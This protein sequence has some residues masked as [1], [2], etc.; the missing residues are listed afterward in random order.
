MLKWFVVLTFLLTS[1]GYH[2]VG[3]GDGSVFPQMVNTA[4]L[5]S[6]ASLTG[7]SIAA[8]LSFIWQQQALLPALE[9]GNSLNKEHVVV[10]IEQENIVFMPVG[11][12][13]SGLAVQYRLQ[14]SAMLRMYHQNA[15]IWQSGAIMVYADVFGASDPSVTEAERERL[16]EQLYKMW[17]KEALARLKSGF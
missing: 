4:T 16:T 3:Q 12:D 17:A 8:E 15:L 6:N 5:Q 7:K 2:L 10:R 11:F 9:A 13:A 1:C 14:L